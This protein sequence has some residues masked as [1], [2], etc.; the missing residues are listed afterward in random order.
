M[1]GLWL[2]VAALSVS[3]A[4]ARAMLEIRNIQAAYGPVGPVRASADYYP[5][6]EV[7]FRFLVAGIRTN[8]AGKLSF[9]MVVTFTGPSDIVLL[10][11]TIP[12]EGV[13]A[14]GS[15][16]LPGSAQ[17]TLGNDFS[18]GVYALT[19]TVR[20]KVAATEARFRREITINPAAFAIVAPRFFYDANGKAPA[21]VVGLVGQTLYFKLKVIGF[22]RSRDKIDVN[23]AVRIL[24]PGTRRV[25]SA[26]I[27]FDESTDDV[28]VVKQA[29]TVTFSGNM[30]LNRAGDFL[31]RIEVTDRMKNQSIALEMPMHVANP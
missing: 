19:V 4:P 8:A 22:D 29:T 1:R 11:R 3:A 14:L 12:V 2:A 18:P 28:N 10:N 24:D 16:S 21:P 7:F 31:L 27:Q 9:D 5:G 30:S 23:L 15:D 13:Y 26:P 25:I 20:D 6:D 17:V